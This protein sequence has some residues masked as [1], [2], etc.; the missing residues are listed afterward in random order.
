[1]EFRYDVQ[2]P[3]PR[4]QPQRTSRLWRKN[5]ALSR[6]GP[7]RPWRARRTGARRPG[8]GVPARRPAPAHPR[9]DR[10]D[11]APRLRDHPRD[12]EP[13]WR[14]VCAVARGRLPDA[15]DARGA[16]LRTSATTE[17]SKR[18]YTITDAGTAHLTANQ[19]TVDAIFARIEDAGSGPDF[20][21]RIVRAMANLRFALRLRLGRG[22]I[23]D[24]AAAKIAAALDA[25]AAEIERS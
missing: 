5:D 8:T 25:A 7:S 17:G 24:T 21:P 16:W 2:P 15:D 14:G 1:M 13:P 20:G 22:G 9:A 6:H 4:S 10:R 11:A 23:D 18:Q 3:Q 12:R 19:A